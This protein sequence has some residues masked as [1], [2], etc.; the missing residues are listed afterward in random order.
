MTENSEW[1]YGAAFQ[2]GYQSLVEFHKALY[3]FLIYIN[4]L[5]YGIKNWILKFAD[6]TRI[7]SRVSDPEDC[8]SLQRLG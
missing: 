6:D 1:L 8:V 2:A 4:D 7:F 5:D 3:W